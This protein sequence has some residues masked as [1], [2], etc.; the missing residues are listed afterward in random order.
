MKINPKNNQ[1]NH[2]SSSCPDFSKISNS[3]EWIFPLISWGPNTLEVILHCP[4]S[5]DDINGY[6]LVLSYNHTMPTLDV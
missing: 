4:S 6:S 3:L 5:A 1:R 2:V